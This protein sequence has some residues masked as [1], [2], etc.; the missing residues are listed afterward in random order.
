MWNP[1]SL[2][3]KIYQF[4][5]VLEDNSI[6]LAFICE[7]WF[8]SQNN[9]VT[10]LLKEFGF[11]TFHSNRTD[12]GGGGVAIISRGNFQPK[13]EKVFKYLSFE[14]VL[15][16]LKVKNS[17]NITVIVIYR[18]F[19][20]PFAT[21]LEEFQVFIEYVTQNFKCY[22]ICGDFNVH[23]NKPTDTQCIKFTD[24]LNTFSLQQSVK[25]PTHELG[26]TLDLIISDPD[27][28]MVNNV[29]VDNSDIDKS[30]HS[31]IYFNILSNIESCSTKVLSYRDFNSVDM[32][33]FHADISLGT[34]KYLSEASNLDFKSCIELYNNIYSDTVNK[35]A[36]IITKVVNAVN[37]PRWMDREY[38][39]QRKQRRILYKEWKNEKSPENRTNYEVTRDAVIVL[40]KEK[41][42]IYYSNVIKSNSQLQLFSV[43]NGLF[44]NTNQFSLPFTENYD[45]LAAKFNNYFVDKIENI[46]NNLPTPKA[47]IHSH[48]NNITTFNLF[49]EVSMCDLLKHVNGSKIKT[50]KNDPIPAFLLKSST[51]QLLPSILHLVNSSLATGSIEGLKD[52]VIVPILKKAGLDLDSLSNY[53]PVCGGMYVDKIIQKCV[54]VQLCDHMDLNNLNIPY[55]SGYKS[56]HSCETVLLNIVDRVLL[57]LDNGM[58]CILLLLDLSAAFDTV[59][60]DE[61]IDILENELGLS[62]TV[63]EWFKSFLYGR[64]QATSVKGCTS[65][66]TDVSYGVPQ[67][68]VLGP[69]LF[70]IYIRNFIKLLTDAGFIVH[71]Y[72]DDH[73]VISSFRIEFQY[74]ALGHSLPKCLGIISEF[75]TSH[76]LK[77]NASKSKLLIFSPHNIRDKMCFDNV[78]IGSNLFLPVSSDAMNLGARIDSDLNF[79]SHISMLLSLSYKH[80]TN[81]GRTRKYLTSDEI[82]T[83]VHA[84]IMS[85]L[86]NCNSI[87]YGISECE[88]GRLQR[89]QNSCARL[90]YGR[91]KFD[92]VTDLFYKLHWL[93]VKQRIFYKALLF[94]FKIFLGIAPIYLINCLTVTDIEDR[95]LLVPRTLTSYGDRAFTNYAPRLWNALPLYIRKS[96]TISYFKS[97]LKHHLFSNYDEFKTR[98]NRY[99]TYI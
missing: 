11:S 91:K 46:R 34:A 50:A 99:N 10:A 74:S 16:T 35:H 57:N 55:Q 73:Q 76:F 62:G 13:F 42:R 21:F 79:S 37:R 40:G 4:L 47:N 58:C 85:R 44:D 28:I 30:D 67:G 7:T 25:S 96:A 68:S 38:V 33:L 88:I 59:D 54:L 66:F 43:F 41:R 70:N 9:M 86:D 83:L 36:P 81:I 26:N 23:V 56:A 52:S 8:Q 77:L 80:V 29:E 18:H 22:V 78:Y 53:R 45:L 15:Q 93:P 61:L 14:C 89:L 60:H 20:E 5:Q 95:V 98:V 84:L 39:E 92:H 51:S 12:K 27:C 69:V 49:K 19:G 63:L 48:N 32:P 24:I 31:L 82:R 87:L 6:H 97:H 2:N 1:K 17:P 64:K 71:G 90:I 65:E 3:N 72:A 94:V 75:M